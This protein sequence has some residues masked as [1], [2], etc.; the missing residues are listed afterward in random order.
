[1]LL[2][3]IVDLTGELQRLIYALNCTQTTQLIVSIH[4]EYTSHNVRVSVCSLLTDRISTQHYWPA[5]VSLTVVVKWLY[6]FVIEWFHSNSEIWMGSLKVSSVDF[7]SQTPP[8][9]HSDL[10]QQEVKVQL[11]SVSPKIPLGE[12]TIETEC[13]EHVMKRHIMLCTM[14]PYTA[15]YSTGCETVLSRH[16]FLWHIHTP[17]C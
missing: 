1:M 11:R 6:T 9:H 13:I 2:R 5:R 12:H 4:W 10:L 16:P 15:V 14:Q 8:W 3:W 7:I 17:I